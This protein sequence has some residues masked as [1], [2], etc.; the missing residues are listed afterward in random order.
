MIH[1][2]YERADGRVAGKDDFRLRQ[3]Y[4]YGA[5]G[6]MAVESGGGEL[7]KQLLHDTYDVLSRRSCRIS[8]RSARPGTGPR[9]LPLAIIEPYLKMDT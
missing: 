8:G 4:R 9:I 7:V 1:R 6:T 5:L 3:P 2:S